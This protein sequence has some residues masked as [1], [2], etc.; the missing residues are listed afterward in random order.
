M[1]FNSFSS[2]FLHSPSW[3]LFWIDSPSASS[4]QSSFFYCYS[5]KLVSIPSQ[6][7]FLTTSWI[8]QKA[9]SDSQELLEKETL[10]KPNGGRKSNHKNVV[11]LNTWC[12]KEPNHPPSCPVLLLQH[13]FAEYFHLVL[14]ESRVYL[15]RDDDPESQSTAPVLQGS[16]IH[17]Q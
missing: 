15:W 9:W 12:T 8:I 2:A 11:P 7:S 3:R 4:S 14:D 6:S 5:V 16:G 1:Q 10:Q 13:F 17:L